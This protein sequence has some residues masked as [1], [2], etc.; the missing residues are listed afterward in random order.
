MNIYIIIGN[1]NTRKSSTIR[2]LSGVRDEHLFDVKTI[3][4]TLK[5]YIK[6]TSLQEAKI[7][8]IDAV[9]YLK[10][11]ISKD[12]D[13]DTALICLW[14]DEENSPHKNIVP[15]LCCNYLN[16]FHKANFIIQKIIVFNKK[17]DCS[18]SLVNGYSIIDTI[19]KPSNEIAS[20]IRKIWGWA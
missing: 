4:A 16:E 19:G 6:T 7:K 12:K 13:C 9:E 17:L 14:H 1:E 8:T 20:E 15:E 5:V 18:I 2:A 3:S 11:K 10:R